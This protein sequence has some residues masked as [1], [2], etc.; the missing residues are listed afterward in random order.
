MSD[1]RGSIGV[2]IECGVRVAYGADDARADLLGALDAH[3]AWRVPVRAGIAA[4]L[5]AEG[6]TDADS[7]AAAVVGDGALA[8][9]V[10]LVRAADVR[11]EAVAWAWRDR[12]ALG[13]LTLLVGVPGLGKSMLAL[14]LAARLSRGD[15]PG[16][17]GA[18]ADAIIASAE[19]SPSHTLVPRL[20]AAGA[21]LDRVHLVRVAR[22]GIDVGLTL[23][24]DV[25]ELA[26]R[27]RDVGAR[28]CIVDPIM[29][30]LA[31]GIDS[32]RDHSIRR[33]LAPLHQLA[34]DA[35]C[36]VLPVG[37]LN[38][39]PTGDIF[40]RVGGSVGLTGAARSILLMTA[41]PDA[42][43]DD[44]ARVLSHA[45]SNIGRMASAL[46]VRIES[47][48]VAG[49]DGQDIP[50]A[51][52]V[53][54]AEAPHIRVDDVLSAPE[55]DETRSARDEA[56]EWLRSELADGERESRAIRRAAAAEGIAP[57]TLARARRRLGVV[58]ERATD[59]EGRVRGWTMRLPASVPP[60][61]GTL[62]RGTLDGRAETHTAT[63]VP[64][65]AATSS[66]PHPETGTLDPA[67]PAGID[68]AIDEG[69][70]W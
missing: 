14:W 7:A 47:R 44:C 9:G 64:A 68:Y 61:R 3:P 32:H 24:D 6:R 10:R 17:V 12:I 16:D 15:L 56:M 5:H 30:H 35:G 66:V 28:L 49:P 27:V 26:A 36:A 13:V 62:D 48:V 52:A 34:E 70:G 59:A 55:D 37:H 22:D 67:V 4:Q 58:T 2:A 38:K 33:A 23:P 18:P 40:A 60:D 41:D 21:N 42:E 54:G 45:K 51:R 53:P 31:G 11:P 43:D 39:A 50:T 25:G 57:R 69:D 29:A 1:A 63:T 8:D 19:D 20:L 65:R 46:R